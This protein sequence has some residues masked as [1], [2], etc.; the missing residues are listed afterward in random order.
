MLPP[1][2]GIQTGNVND[3]EFDAYGRMITT[4]PHG[5]AIAITDPVVPTQMIVVQ[6]IIGGAQ[7]GTSHNPG[8]FYGPR[9]VA[10]DPR[11]QE[12]Y[13][14]DTGLNRVQVF[15]NQGNFIRMFGAG[16]GGQ[17]LG[18]SAPTAIEIDSFG[19]VYIATSEGL[20]IFNEYGQPISYGSI[21]GYVRDKTTNVPLDNAVVSISSTYR[22]F[23]T[24][25]DEK[26][27]FRFRSVPQGDHTLIANRNGY[28]AGNANIFVNGGYKTTATL[29]LE[30]TGVGQSGVGNITG[31]VVSSLDGDPVSGLAANVVGTG[32]TDT[33]N[34]NGEF[35]LY[36]VPEGDHVVQL[37]ANA[38]VVYETDVHVNSDATTP[39]GYIYLPI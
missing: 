35:T 23:A 22:V 34:G 21:E 18:F 33:T 6:R 28:Q 37:L 24:N 27:F 4:I 19:N 32:I 39:L 7:D 20:Q 29:Y 9:G 10:V 14:T 2:D 36:S 11:N 16:I 3:F 26:G 31:K 12:I 5:N 17:G 38:I 25:T 13:I 15:D 8:D 30:R 1:R